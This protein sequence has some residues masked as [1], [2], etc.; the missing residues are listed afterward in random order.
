MNLLPRESLLLCISAVFIILFGLSTI[1]T[2][3]ADNSLFYKQ[4]IIIF[5]SFF[6]FLIF[7]FF[8]IS[9]LKKNNFI[10]YFYIFIFFILSILLIFGYV[11]NGAQSWFKIGGVSFQPV[12][13]AKIAI[14][15]ILAKYFYKRHIEIAHISHIIISFIYTFILAFLVL[16]QPDFGS[17]LVIFGIWAI[18]L[19]VSGISKKQIL[20]LFLSFAIIV[21]SSWQFFLKDYQ[22][23]RILNFLDPVRDIRG[24]G[25]NVYQSMIAVG[26]GGIFGKGVDFGTQSNLAYLPEYQTDFIFAAFAEEWGFVGSLLVIFF[27]LI[28]IGKLFLFSTTL[29]DNFEILI[30]L[31]FASYFLIHFIINVGMNIGLLPVT[32]IP[33]PFMSS[34]GTHILVES[35]MLG[36]TV[37]IMRNKKRSRFQGETL[38]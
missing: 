16:L 25:Y 32:G 14:I 34:G 17:A 33:L 13:F 18:V 29:N 38:L 5:I 11:S 6:T 35:I 1:Y 10:L 36:I 4:I 26:S 3:S 15:F 12:E 8:D 23:D 27:F 31:G 30:I 28:I 20:F 21:F 2:G 9:N 7:S 19:F 24:S 37:S 22:K